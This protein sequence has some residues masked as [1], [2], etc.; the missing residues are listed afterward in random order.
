MTYARVGKQVLEFNGKNNRK[1]YST[2]GKEQTRVSVE[3][4]AP[5]PSFVLRMID[6]VLQP[7]S[8]ALSTKINSII[9]G[10]AFEGCNYRFW[11]STISSHMGVSATDGKVSITS[12]A[13]ISVFGNAGDGP[14]IRVIKE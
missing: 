6:R 2:A 9:V 7:L 11:I 14:T 5:P 4:Q 10:S 1:N 13:S 3:R 12:K 8:R